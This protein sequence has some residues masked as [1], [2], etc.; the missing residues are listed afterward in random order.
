MGKYLPRIQHPGLQ[1]FRVSVRI[2]KHAVRQR[3]VVA[4]SVE[5]HGKFQGA[6]AALPI[7]GIQHRDPHGSGDACLAVP[8]FPAVD[9]DFAVSG[10]NARNIRTIVRHDDFCGLLLGQRNFSAA[11]IIVQGRFFQFQFHENPFLSRQ[12]MSY[13]MN[14]RERLCLDPE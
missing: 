13:P 7:R 6:N 8:Q 4:F 3:T 2:E 1:K 9:V 14:R 11:L 10:N 12:F 5:G